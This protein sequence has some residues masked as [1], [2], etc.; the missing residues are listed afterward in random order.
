MEDQQPAAGDLTADAVSATDVTETAEVDTEQAE[1]DESTVATAESG[2]TSEKDDGE[3]AKAE[4]REKKATPK[5]KKKAAKPKKDRDPRAK[6]LR[7]KRVAVAI[8]VVASLLFVGSAAFA[9]A[10]MHAYL[11][12]R[13]TVATKLKVARTAAAAITTLWSYTPENIDTLADRAAKYLS[14]DFAAQYRKVMSEIA[15]PYKQ[16]KITSSTEVTG[17]AVESLVGPNAI[18]IVYTNTT[19]KSALKKNIPGL[20]YLAY[21]VNMTRDDHGRWLV[22]RMSTVTSVNMTP[23][24]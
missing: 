18:A 5:G 10:T 6:R 7:G 4:E 3:A 11:S 19:S 22:T 1:P 17:A 2:G 21:R 8:A 24:L 13:A 12:E 23:Q 15:S 16:H 20:L 9:G 14:G